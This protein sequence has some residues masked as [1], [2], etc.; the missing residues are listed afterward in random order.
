MGKLENNWGMIRD[1][2]GVNKGL[3]E[4]LPSP[5]NVGWPFEFGSKL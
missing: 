5:R 1:F 4:V 2:L 3:T